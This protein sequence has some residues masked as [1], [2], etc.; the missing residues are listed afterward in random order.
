M[1][2]GTVQRKDVADGGVALWPILDDAALRGLD[3]CRNPIWFSGTESGR[4]E[5]ANAAAL[6]FWNATDAGSLRRDSEIV[7]ESARRRIK[8]YATRL[9][10]GEEIEEDWTVYPGGTPTHVRIA[11]SACCFHGQNALFCEVL[12]QEVGDDLPARRGSE[13]S[14]AETFHQS[15]MPIIVCRRNGLIAAINDAGRNAFNG[16]CR[17]PSF[18]D[19]RHRNGLHDPVAAI[20]FE[21]RAAQDRGSSVRSSPQGPLVAGFRA[22][23]FRCCERG[24]SRLPL[25]AR[26]DA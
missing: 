10:L 2:G 23:R 1:T 17:R 18:V 21:R 5:W 19:H 11:I 7:S 24:G 9:S 12:S 22:G 15:P 20:G 25:P 3:L 8:N 6:G 16:R 14:Y 26:R 4:I 13:A